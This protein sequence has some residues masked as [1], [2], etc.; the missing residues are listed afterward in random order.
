MGNTILLVYKYPS[1]KFSLF[2]LFLSIWKFASRFVVILQ[3]LH[4]DKNRV[5]CKIIRDKILLKKEEVTI[6]FYFN[7]TIMQVARK[8]GFDNSQ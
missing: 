8:T 7:L 2:F 3:L 4:E 6:T 5:S 1:K